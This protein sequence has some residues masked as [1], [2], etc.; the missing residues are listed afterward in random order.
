MSA[1]S[2]LTAVFAGEVADT[3]RAS[4]RQFAIF[5][6]VPVHWSHHP[7]SR[8]ILSEPCGPSGAPSVVWLDTPA[9]VLLP[10]QSV[11]Y[12]VWVPMAASQGASQLLAVALL[13]KAVVRPVDPITGC[14]E[15]RLLVR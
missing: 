6:L 5:V 8:K 12:M 10:W 11:Q 1:P 7:L 3:V 15:R 14:Q 2:G 9:A 4:V 13:R